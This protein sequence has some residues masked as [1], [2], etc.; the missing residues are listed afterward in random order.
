MSLLLNDITGSI[1]NTP[2]IKLNRI[3]A[4]L[5]ANIY[6]KCEYFNPLSS[7]KDRIG[8][9]MIKAGEASGVLKPDSV[10]V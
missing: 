4:D 2:L 6:L 9:A 1:G 7:V 8:N 3:S 10:I 5:P